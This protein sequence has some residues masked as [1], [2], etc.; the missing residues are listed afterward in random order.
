MSMTKPTDSEPGHEGLGFANALRDCLA[1]GVIWFGPHQ[2]HATL[3]REAAHI[4]GL[5]PEGAPHT[6]LTAL[7]EPLHAIARQVLVSACPVSEREFQ[8]C[9]PVGA[10]LSLR[11][12]AFLVPT[13]GKDSGVVLV[14]NNL[15]PARQLEP[16]LAQLDR[17][18]NAG[19]LAAS[20][21][22]E[23]KNA[24][25]AGKT[26]IDLLL[27]KNQEAELVE[28]VRREMG[29]IDAIVT[30]MLNFAG[31]ARPGFG[32]VSLHEVLE[33]SLRLVQHRVEG[34]YLTLT[35]SFQAAPD[36][37]QGDDYELQQ[38]FVNL[39]LNALDAMGPSGTLTV[40]TE[41][42]SAESAAACEPKLPRKPYLR[43]TIQD[44]GTGIPAASLSRLFEPFFTTKASGTGLGLP[45][46]RRIIR[47]HHGAISVESQPGL[48]TTF[49]IL[50]PA[51]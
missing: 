39:F 10:P 15:A 45:I 7:P 1:C 33:H 30:G 48:G 12:S 20:M 5:D 31:P 21:A 44:T 41:S 32:R 18:A 42:L 50:L 13:T 11:V 22:H 19:V 14:L 38:A 23:I 4:L 6:P 35:R 8:W 37:V 43:L 40:A 29:R 28:I 25:V 36:E 17:L 47:D 2:P 34:N 3:T 27:E 49:R 26:F 16:H 46:T 24:L 51:S 9:P